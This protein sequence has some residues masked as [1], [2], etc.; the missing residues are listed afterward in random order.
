M[1]FA[2]I[3]SDL[4]NGKKAVLRKEEAPTGDGGKRQ[5][6]SAG[7]VKVAVVLKPL[8]RKNSSLKTNHRTAA[9]DPPASQKKSLAVSRTLSTSTSSLGS[10]VTGE[11]HLTAPRKAEQDVPGKRGK[12]DEEEPKC[13]REECVGEQAECTGDTSLSGAAVEKPRTPAR[14]S[15][16]N[17]CSPAP[18]AEFS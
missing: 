3:K 7:P 4:L 12:S 13:P 11:K 10:E 14:V 9:G 1:S 17:K 8:R 6:S 15:L 5:R 16:R 2:Q 18:R